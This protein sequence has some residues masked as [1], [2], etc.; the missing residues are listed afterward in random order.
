ML[1]TAG[2]CAGRTV[3]QVELSFSRVV[4]GCL[5]SQICCRVLPSLFVT[6]ATYFF[7]AI[8]QKIM[9]TAKNAPMDEGDV[10]GSYV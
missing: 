2:N 10:W 6:E 8:F 9:I 1:C 3:K 7:K 4:S 5:I